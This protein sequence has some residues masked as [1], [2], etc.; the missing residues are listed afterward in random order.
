MENETKNRPGF[1]PWISVWT[2]PR[3]TIREIVAVNPNRSL[4]L[5]AAIYG[6]SSI[7]STFQSLY[8]GH[9]IGVVEILFI[10]LLLS[11]IWGYI[12]FSIWSFFVYY[13][14]KLFKGAGNFKEVRAAY[15][16][17][18]PPLIVNAVLWV[19]LMATFGRE[20]FMNVPETQGLTKLEVVVLFLVLLARLVTTI[21]SLVIYINTLSEVQKFSVWKS[22]GNIFVSAVCVG[23]IFYVVLL[24]GAHGVGGT[25]TAFSQVHPEILRVL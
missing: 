21:W 19:L 10:A 3:A 20:L 1:N 15:A 17:S 5:L 6:F 11:P 8:I 7:L 23:V 9:Q 13:I 25:T 22:V 24:L 2:Q 16:W 12:G 18:C 4:W 14:G